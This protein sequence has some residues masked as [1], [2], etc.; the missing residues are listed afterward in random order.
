ME[1]KSYRGNINHLKIYWT[2]TVIEPTYKHIWIYLPITMRLKSH[3]DNINHL[4]IEINLKGH[5]DN[6]RHLSLYTE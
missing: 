6:F 1:L 5:Q 2:L 4:K 3:R